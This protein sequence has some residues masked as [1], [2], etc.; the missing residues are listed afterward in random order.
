MTMRCAKALLALVLVIMMV[1]PSALA[2]QY[3]TFEDVPGEWNNYESGVRWMGVEYAPTSD[4]AWVDTELLDGGQVA[5][6][7]FE[8]IAD[9]KYAHENP[10]NVCAYLY[11][12][13]PGEI[14]Y[15]SA[16]EGNWSTKEY[17][18]MNYIATDGIYVDLFLP[19]F[20]QDG[21]LLNTDRIYLYEYEVNGKWHYECVTFYFRY[22]GEETRSFLPPASMS[23]ADEETEAA[24]APEQAEESDNT[25]D[26]ENTDEMTLPSDPADS[27]E[28]TAGGEAYSVGIIGGADGPTSVIIAG[29]EN[30][31]FSGFF[32]NVLSGI[33]SGIEE[34]M[35]AEESAQT[36][37]QTQDDPAPETEANENAEESYADEETAAEATADV[38]KGG[39]RDFFSG[40]FGGF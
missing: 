8:F 3:V 39:M 23:A 16:F 4:Y 21:N 38:T 25:A 2:V 20:D 1:A 40:M 12:D 28:D 30:K 5:P 27:N 13:A 24:P 11:I 36:Q 18:F 6:G 26:P 31:G 14:M 29:S 7:V 19:S 9:P 34:E 33:A 32:E 17:M 37:T 15:V 10:N 35:T 22:D